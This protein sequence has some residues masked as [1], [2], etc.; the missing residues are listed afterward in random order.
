MINFTEEPLKWKVTILEAANLYVPFLLTYHGIHLSFYL[1]D[2]EKEII[3]FS[4]SNK[5]DK[6][7]GFF[8]KR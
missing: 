3:F 2:Y 1:T 8:A 6:P 4:S 5:F 7:T